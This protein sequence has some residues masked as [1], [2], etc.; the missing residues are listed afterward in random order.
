MQGIIDGGL[1]E[2]VSEEVAEKLTAAAN[3]IISGSKDALNEISTLESSEQVYDVSYSGK[4]GEGGVSYNASNDH[5]N[6][7]IGSNG[8]PGGFVKIAE[9]VGHEM[10]HAYQYE[11]GELS[12]LSDNSGYGALYDIGDETAAYNRG[13]LM[14]AGIYSDLSKWDNSKTR[15]FGASAPIP[16]YVG[17]PDGPL[18]FNSS[19]V[20]LFGRTAT[21]GIL[22]Q[23]TNERYKGW[24]KTYNAAK[25]NE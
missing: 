4:D 15:Q 21:A 12:L 24:K 6:I 19:L 9:I 17:L 11:M 7:G 14:S 2:G 1:P 23:P 13:R 3:L 22:N 25:S 20:K 16:L 8:F 5:I 10:L 18:N